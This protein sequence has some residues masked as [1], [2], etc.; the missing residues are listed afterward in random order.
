MYSTVAENI[1]YAKRSA[2]FREIE[3]AAKI[4]NASEFIEKLPNKYNTI[5]GE[6]GTRLSGGQRQRIGIA[7]AV[8]ADPKILVFDEATSNL[9][10]ESEKLIQEAINKIAKDKTIIIIAHRLSTIKMA[11]KIAVIENGQV[12]EEECICN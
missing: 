8:L 1:S 5:V 9:D 12:V 11:N 4:A 2:S 6:R 3:A 7:R 10:V